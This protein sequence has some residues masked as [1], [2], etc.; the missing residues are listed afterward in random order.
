VG[1]QC[2][3]PVALPPGKTQYPLY[4]RLSGPQGW[5]GGENL[6]PQWDSIPR[7]SGPE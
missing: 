3:A 2:H 4:R 1:G 7:L 6:A 5:T